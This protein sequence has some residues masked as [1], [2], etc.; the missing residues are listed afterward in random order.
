MAYLRAIRTTSI[1]HRNGL[2]LL[3]KIV[4]AAWIATSVLQ[5]IFLF[6]GLG[7]TNSSNMNVYFQNRF[8]RQYY[9]TLNLIQS[10]V[11]L[12]WATSVDSYILLKSASAQGK[13]I[14]KDIVSGESRY[15][16][17]QQ[18]IMV[19]VNLICFCVDVA[20]RA[21]AWSVPY[22]SIDLFM[23]ALATC[24]DSFSFSMMDATFQNTVPGSGFGSPRASQVAKGV[25]VEPTPTSSE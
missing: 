14:K 1:V 7:E 13:D 19:V 2:D 8:Y 24:I 23:H 6:A 10:I 15:I 9:K 21:W 25:E 18:T 4:V 12:L 5:C 3:Q 16:W 22:E 17:Y 20:V 11:Y